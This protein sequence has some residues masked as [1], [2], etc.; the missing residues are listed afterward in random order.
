MTD[1]RIRHAAAGLIVATGLLL[2]GCGLLPTPSPTP[3]PDPSTSEPAGE[4]TQAQQCAQVVADV[5]G[6]A[7]DV[8]RVVEMVGSD[9]FGAL[10]LVGSISNRVGDLQVR[11]T[12]PELLERIAEIQS[13]WDAVVAD[14]QGSL[15]SGDAAGLERVVAG[16]TELGE[17]VSAL[18]EF[19][20][21]T[22]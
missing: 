9:P 20:A 10:A 17:Q 12:D 6:I 21:G 15:T 7:T 11:V 4:Q 19:C 22:A 3:V 16:L 5:Q 2:T 14:A 18:Q 1:T 8:G 13:G